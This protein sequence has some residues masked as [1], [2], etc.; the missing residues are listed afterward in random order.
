MLAF[1][2]DVL[3]ESRAL[4]EAATAWANE[5]NEMRLGAARDRLM[6]A[7]LAWK[8]AQAFRSGPFASTQAFQRAAFWPAN[9]NSIDAV[10]A[11]P[12]VTELVVQGLGVETRGLFAIEYLLFGL[13][14]H[15][16]QARSYV[17]E[18]AKNVLGY[19]KRLASTLG[20]AR[21]FAA[22]FAQADHGSVQALY[23]Q[24]LDSMDMLRGKFVRVSRAVSEHT[25]LHEAV[26][27]YFSRSSVEVARALLLGT[28]RLYLGG[29]SEIVASARTEI[30]E[31]MR[32]AFTETD[33]RFA[34]IVPTLDAALLQRPEAFQGAVA[35]LA[36]LEHLLKTDIAS[37][38]EV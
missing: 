30:D 4:D 1:A 9:P 7:T 34:A 14:K 26:E 3:T 11:G 16:L 33:A 6:A 29:L 35:A 10:V 18:L 22:Q 23:A 13:S 8:R 36:Q 28:K 20:D 17:K 21:A 24:S 5:P 27:G 32:A 25:A 2:R 19:A 15:D 37:A 31:Q 12:P 38:L